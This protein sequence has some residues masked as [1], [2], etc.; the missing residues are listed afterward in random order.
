M[1][2][3]Y[4]NKKDYKNCLCEYLL[5]ILKPESIVITAVILAKKM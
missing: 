3:L 4:E 5:K 1:K 2:W